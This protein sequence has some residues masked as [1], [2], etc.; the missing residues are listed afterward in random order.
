M[1]SPAFAGTAMETVTGIVPPAG[2]DVDTGDEETHAQSARRYSSI[3]N[4]HGTPA[5]PLP[6]RLSARRTTR[7]SRRV[8]AGSRTRTSRTFAWCAVFEMVLSSFANSV[9]A[10]YGPNGSPPQFEA[11]TAHSI[12]MSV[13]E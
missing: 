5:K 4:V 9:G 3:V 6:E 12:A 1:P 11:F 8:V 2:S 13:Y 7:P 10:G